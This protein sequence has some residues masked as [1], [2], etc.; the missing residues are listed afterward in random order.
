MNTSSEGAN[1]I[2][3]PFY[4]REGT[5]CAEKVFGRS[6]LQVGSNNKESAGA[7]DN[8]SG[9]SSNNQTQNSRK[10]LQEIPM[11]NNQWRIFLSFKFL[12]VASTITSTEAV[13][14]NERGYVLLSSG[15][16]KSQSIS[17]ATEEIIGSW[18]SSYPNYNPPIF[19]SR[20]FLAF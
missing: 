16:I 19:I 8:G 2:S 1:I 15:R 12:S 11:P 13:A 17:A 6:K 18:F 7:K 20:T 10:V 3:S 14:Q 9:K 4:P 5:R